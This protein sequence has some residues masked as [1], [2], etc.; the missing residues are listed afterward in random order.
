MG[1]ED[2]QEI[3]EFLADL[4]ANQLASLMELDEYPRSFPWRV[5][6][7]LSAPL[8]H[9]TLEA[10]RC[11][12]KFVTSF[13]D[14]LTPK[15]TLHTF[16]AITR[17]QPYRDLMT[18]AE[19]LGPFSCSACRFGAVRRYLLCTPEYHP[20]TDRIRIFD[21][22]AD[23]MDTDQ[24]TAFRRTVCSFCGMTA[25]SYS[26]LLTSLPN[27]LA[28]ND[29][30]DAGR[31]HSKQEKTDPCNLHAV[32]L[33]SSLKRPSGCSTLELTD[34]Q[35]QEPLKGRTVKT[36]CHY[37]LKPRD[38]E[39]GVDCEGLTRHRFNSAYTK[40]HVFCQRLRLLRLLQSTWENSPGDDE[41]R[42][43]AVMEAFKES[44][45][46]KLIPKQC[47]LKWHNCSEDASRN[48]V[49][50]AGP[51]AV[52]LLP[53]TLVTDSQPESY[54]FSSECLPRDPTFVGP[55][56]GFK[57]C[58]TG[59]VLAGGRTLAWAQKTDFMSMQAYIADYM[60]PG[61]PSE[62][63]SRLC[64]ALKL[65]GHSKLNYKKRVELFL[66][67]MGKDPASIQQILEEIPEQEPRP[68]RR[69][70]NVADEARILSH[71]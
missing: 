21:F 44:W 45:V 70:E 53:L 40:P 47:F 31:R 46:S 34:E 71:L 32:A 12:W 67:H 2:N 58:L 22:E 50:S 17:H 24:S 61:I 60:I 29:L 4:L 63:L 10:M 41:K 30:R 57:I 6:A 28:F 13:V 18:K 3:L 38:I 36:R 15:S 37:A 11:E 52:Q 35:W 5:V 59:P 19:T 55:I 43:D 1:V 51:H 25:D 8:R 64:S 68:R 23:K 48:L 42:H 16:M 14:R 56:D 26:P 69:V 27:E 65:R 7:T 9:N 62:S 66:Q 54:S 49:L 39:L 20:L 33:K